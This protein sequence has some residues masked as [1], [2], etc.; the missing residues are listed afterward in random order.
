VQ[1]EVFRS[2]KKRDRKSRHGGDAGLDDER[3]EAELSLIQRP[4]ISDILP[5]VI[6]RFVVRA[7]VGI[8]SSVRLVIEWYHEWQM[9]E[10]E[11]EDE[12]PGCIVNLR[13][14]KIVLRVVLLHRLM[15]N[16]NIHLYIHTIVLLLFSDP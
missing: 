12:Q 1:Q 14:S 10:D 6:F 9:T 8:P 16:N 3:L 13:Y 7:V 4:Q 15:I 2:K 5:C 11:T